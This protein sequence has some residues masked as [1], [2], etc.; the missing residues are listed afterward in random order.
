MKLQLLVLFLPKKERQTVPG[1]L[2]EEFYLVV[3]EFGAKK[4]RFWYWKQVLTSI[5]PF[6]RS[7]VYRIGGGRGW[8]R[9]AE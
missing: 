5:W 4:A 3:G 8:G 6:I 9:G 7:A 2:E 1:D